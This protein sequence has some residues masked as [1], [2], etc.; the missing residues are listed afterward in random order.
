MNFNSKEITESLIIPKGLSDMLPSSEKVDSG[1]F[2]RLLDDNKVVA[3]YKMYW[4]LGIL[5]EVSTGKKEIPFKNLIARMIVYAWYPTLQFKLNFGVFDNLKKPI[6]YIALKY[7]FKSNCNEKDLFEFIVKSDDKEL[8]MM[9]RELTYN[10]PYRLIS[11]FFSE[12]LRGVKNHEKNNIIVEESLKS[13][14]C[15]YKIIKEDENKIVIN[16]GWDDYLKD[17]YRII[18]CWIYYK[19]VCFLQ[20]RNPNTPAIAFKLETPKKEK[21]LKPRKIWKEII[22]EDK[23]NDIYTDREFSNENFK[24]YGVLS[25]DHF[26]PWS[27]VLHDEMWNLAPTFKNINSSKSDKLLYFNDCINDFS[28]IQYKA[29]KYLCLKNKAHELEDYMNILNV[30]NPCE[31]YRYSDESDFQDK[32]KKNISPLYQIAENQGF[33]VIRKQYLL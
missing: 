28:R 22:I 29:F 17:N 12:K 33:E 27:F 15:L 8:K 32:L 14:L 1:A 4:L 25:I 5:D 16:D 23:V 19:L 20:K 9:I 10:V 26:I 21:L 30:D 11:P 18:K 7:K 13:S 3:S 31:Y 2:S 6:N 24:K